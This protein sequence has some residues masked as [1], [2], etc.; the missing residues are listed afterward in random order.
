[1]SRGERPLEDLV[2]PLT[3]FLAPVFFV[4]MGLRTDLAVLVQPTALGLAAALIVAAIAGKQLCSLGVLRKGVNRLAIGI[5]MIPR[6]EVGLIFANVGAGL[7][8][9]GEPVIDSRTFSALVLMVIVTT[10]V[11]PPVFRWSLKR[12]PR[13]PAA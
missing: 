13:Q 6:G 11:T 12:G 7:M 4:L 5:G 1:V 9:N 10:L 2:R 3:D 8:L